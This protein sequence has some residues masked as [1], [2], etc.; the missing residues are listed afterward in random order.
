VATGV[1]TARRDG[2]ARRGQ[3]RAG[4]AL[5]ARAEFSLIIIGLAG[6][7]IHGLAPVAMS[8]V[9]VVAVI[10]PVLAR[11]SGAPLAAHAHSVA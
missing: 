2:V 9:F 8:Y 6:M 1:D 4:T 7:S 11:F 3:W 10:G 5:I